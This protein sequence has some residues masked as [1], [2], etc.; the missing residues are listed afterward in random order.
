M[1][2]QSFTHSVVYSSHFEFRATAS[3]ISQS[4]THSHPSLTLCIIPSHSIGRLRR[5]QGWQRRESYPCLSPRSARG[6]RRHAASV[7][8]A[9]LWC[10]L[11]WRGSCT[12]EHVSA[13]THGRAGDV[14][15]PLPR[16]GHH[17]LTEPQRRPA[18]L[19]DFSLGLFIGWQRRR[20]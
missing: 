3:L 15:V 19:S 1:I 9:R 20:V 4:L 17:C 12:S 7:E 6:R 18:L 14:R 2:H 16:W 11:M 13:C 5:S 10:S 8:M